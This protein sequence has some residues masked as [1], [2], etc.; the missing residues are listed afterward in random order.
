MQMEID[1]TKEQKRIVEL[2]AALQEAMDFIDA[3]VEAQDSPDGP[4]ANP[5]AALYAFLE[6]TLDGN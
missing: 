5:A 3:Y 4:E 1:M 6:Q 2:E